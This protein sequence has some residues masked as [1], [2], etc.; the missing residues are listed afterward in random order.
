MT[1][2][3]YQGSWAL[4]SIALSL[5]L[6]FVA[7]LPSRAQVSSPLPGP[8]TLARVTFEPPSNERLSD[9]VGGASRQAAFCP[10]DGMAEG[11]SLMPL[12]PETK[13]GLTVSE[14]PTLFVYVPETKAEQGY[15]ILKDQT[16]DY[17]YQ[18]QVSIPQEG[19]IVRLTLPESAPALE[20]GTTYQWSFVVAC[21]LPARADSPRVEGWLQRVEPTAKLNN[22][23]GVDSIEAATSYGSE[24]IWYDAV[25][26]LADLRRSQPQTYN[27]EWVDLLSSVGL[28]NVANEPILEP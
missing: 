4:C 24:G 6:A 26:T 13:E 25:T 28:E 7:A 23:Q 11:P 2:K 22:Y 12:L 3:N 21:E 9:S 15:F 19:G 18:T 17:Y 10:Q 20:I 1:R 27:Q 5:N 16:E 8:Q 14:R